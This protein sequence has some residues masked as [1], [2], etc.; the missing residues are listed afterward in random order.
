VNWESPGH[1]GNVPACTTYEYF[2][3]ALPM[4]SW[5]HENV[6]NRHPS[7]MALRAFNSKAPRRFEHRSRLQ[8]SGFGCELPVV[9]AQGKGQQRCRNRGEDETIRPGNQARVK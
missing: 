9:N 5:E 6:P 4:L 2:P 8:S 7:R 1:F 3:L